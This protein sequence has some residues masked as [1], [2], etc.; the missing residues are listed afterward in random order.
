MDDPAHYVQSSG[1]IWFDGWVTKFHF[2]PGEDGEV[3]ILTRGIHNSASMELVDINDPTDTSG[4]PVW[5]HEDISGVGTQHLFT[6]DVANLLHGDI[7]DENDPNF[8]ANYAD[9]WREHSNP[10]MWPAD[11]DVL[12]ATF[13]DGQDIGRW[14][15]AGFKLEELVAPPGLNG[16]YNDDG[17]VNAAD[18]VVW[19]NH[20]DESFDLPNRDGSNDGP[21]NQAD[22]TTWVNNFGNSASASGSAVSVPEPS[23]QMF[24][25]LAF[26][27]WIRVRLD[28]TSHVGLY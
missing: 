19:R 5:R 26:P 10:A 22:Y 21:I 1:E 14:Y 18:Y 16:D 8:G 4:V 27:W 11:P 17:V 2:K 24:I 23:S 25:F 7:T 13:N 12:E 3:Q 15:L 9:G 20:L 28:C 6:R